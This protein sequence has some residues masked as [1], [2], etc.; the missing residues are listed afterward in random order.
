MVILVRFFEKLR[1]VSEKQ[2]VKQLKG[3][4]GGVVESERFGS[5]E[6]LSGESELN[7]R[8]SI[9]SGRGKD[10]DS[11]QLALFWKFRM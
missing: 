5:N 2:Q 4:Y 8:V 10:S 6:Q 3:N 9:R 1:K 11:V 7:R